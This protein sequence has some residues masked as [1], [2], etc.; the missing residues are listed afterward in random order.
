MLKGEA[1]EGEKV[2]VVDCSLFRL[3]PSGCSPVIS[4]SSHFQRPPLWYLTC[5]PFSGLCLVFL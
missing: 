5:L 3:L 4:L 1:S 2:E